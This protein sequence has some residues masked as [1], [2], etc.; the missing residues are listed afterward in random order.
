M[1]L[2][3]NINQLIHGSTV[4]WER[5]E[6]KEGWNPEIILHTICAF[7]NDMNNWGGGYLIIGI[8]EDNGRAILPPPKGLDIKDLDKIQLEL[9]QL[10]HKLTPS[11]FPV[12]EPYE[13]QAKHILVVWVPG[14]DNRPYKAPKNL[15]KGAEKLYYVRRMSSTVR[16]NEQEEQQLIQLTA[17]IPFDDRINHHAAIS[18]LSL[19]LIRIFLQEVKSDLFNTALSM[20]FEDLVRAMQIA[21][22]ANEYLLPINVGLL[23]FSETPEKFFPYSWIEVNIYHDDVGDNFTEK[24]FKG[25]VYLQLKE[26]LSYIKSSVIQEHVKKVENQA[27]TIR[28]Y[29][30]PYSA[31][32]EALANAVYHKNYDLREPIEVNIRLDRIEIL[33]HAGPM[34]PL[35]KDDFTKERIIARKYLNRRIGDFLR[36]L[37]L[38]EGKGTGIPKIRRAMKNNGSK[39][40]I[41]E[42]DD[43]RSYFLTTLFRRFY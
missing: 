14:G 13:I 10:C 20:P 18:D 34:P 4:E 29:N 3:I 41:F 15:R 35:S 2:P 23:F 30:Y 42:T 19:G 17:K 43:D 33:S 11:Y 31:I 6:F 40:P 37:H 16:A 25:A 32:Q 27:E 38:T 9:H 8:A 39:D 7:A 26:A 22:G 1:A 24:V 21:R 12:V 5:I 28:F 36:E